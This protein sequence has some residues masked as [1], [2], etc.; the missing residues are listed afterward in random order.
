MSESIEAGAPWAAT[1][2]WKLATTSAALNTARASDAT[3]Y[4][5]WSSITFRI[6]TCDPPASPQW[7]MSA[8][9]R[10][11]GI[12]AS[13]R[14]KE[15]RGRFWGWGVTKPLRESTRQIVATEGSDPWG[16]RRAR[17]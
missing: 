6:S 14:M 1:A 15:L 2:P 8:C 17:W 5:E 4:L 12:W 7:V 3:R 13:N 16:W 10:S 11:L 9:Q